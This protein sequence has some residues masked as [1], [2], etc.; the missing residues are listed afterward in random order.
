MIATTSLRSISQ[1][2]KWKSS[3]LINSRSGRQK[4]VYEIP[5]RADILIKV[6]KVPQTFERLKDYVYA[7]IPLS[8]NRSLRSEVSHAKQIELRSRKLGI[9]NPISL[10]HGVGRVDGQLGLIVEKISSPTQ[11]DFAPSIKEYFDSVE[12]REEAVSVLNEFTQNLFRLRVVARDIH[13]QN[14]LADFSSSQERPRLVLVDGFGE[15]HLVRVRSWF[16]FIRHRDL[17]SGLRTLARELNLN[18]DPNTRVF[19]NTNFHKW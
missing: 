3:D 16:A 14:V 18:F 10:I 15:R 19:S 5:G 4:I 2:Y 17:V 8:R 9:S 12:S 6:R 7:K 13:S 1:Q 11:G